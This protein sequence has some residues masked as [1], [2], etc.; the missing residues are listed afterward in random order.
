M[1]Y[2]RQESPLYRLLRKGRKLNLPKGQVIG[3]FS[4]TESVHLIE[5]GYVK[6]YLITKEGDKSIQVIY[7]PGDF[8]PLT[9]VYKH[10]FNMDIYSGPEQYYYES[11]SPI[12]IY[13]LPND[14]LAEALGED[15]S[16]YQDLFYAA[17]LRLNSYIHRL[18]SASLGVANRKIAHQLHYLASI[19]GE[20]S[21]E[22]VKIMVP[23]THQT[24]AEILDMARETVSH[25]MVRLQEKGLIKIDKHITVLDME[26]LRKA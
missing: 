12:E 15:P 13:S 5:S 3:A 14:E 8:F 26:K 6:R 23:L 4:G 1:T 22:G 25:R 17:G 16:I 18:E 7:G 11:M 21:S 10:V 9:P 19:F 20:K 24:I 2:R